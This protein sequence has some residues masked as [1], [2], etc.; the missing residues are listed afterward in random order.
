MHWAF[1]AALRAAAG[2]CVFAAVVAMLALP[3][4]A[5]K[6]SRAAA[7]AAQANSLAAALAVA[8][9]E[10]LMMIVS[11]KAQRIDVYRG[12]KLIAS[13]R[14]STGMRGYRTPTGI[15]SVVE[16]RRWH[17]SNIYSGAPM[18]FM[19]RI[20]W[21]GIA[22][23]AGYV[24]NYPASHGCIRLPAAFASSL[25]KTTSL[26]HHVLVVPDEAKMHTFEHAK[27]LQPKPAIEIAAAPAAIVPAVEVAEA[28]QSAQMDAGKM[29]HD[30]GSAGAGQ[31]RQIVVASAAEDVPAVAPEPVVSRAP[32]R[33]L[34]TRRTGRERV[35]DAQTLLSELGFSPGAIDGWMG[36]DTARAV[37]AFQA[38][39]G[40]PQTGMVTEALVERL[41]QAAGKEYFNGHLYLRQELK[42]ILDAPVRIAE[43]DRPLGTHFFIAKHFKEGARRVEWLSLTLTDAGPSAAE[44]LDRIALPEDV[45]ERLSA[46]LRPGSSIIVSDAGLSGLTAPHGGTDF[47]VLAP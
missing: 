41:H 13:S 42:P 1:R 17:R 25:F 18:P 24:P 27:L 15:F 23:H 39:Q 28:Q 11:L 9:K 36:P 38:S 20:T 46:M 26:G 40:L 3:A 19:Q 35:T 31:G 22:L 6:R 43:A 14:V 30:A 44:A 45:R 2:F 5:R 29:A 10:P 34:I 33:I 12:D 21:T 8:S 47:V 7:S 4:E 32:L 16:K 37:K